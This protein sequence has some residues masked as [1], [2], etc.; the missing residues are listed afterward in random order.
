MMANIYNNNILA[1]AAF[2][3]N[4]S[5]LLAATIEAIFLVCGTPNI[6]VSK[7]PLPLKRWHELIVGPRQIVLG[8]VINTIEMTV[9]ITNNY[10]TKV[11][12][13]LALWDPN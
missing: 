10:I 13:L 11:R 8:L 4:M 3:G 5:K 9:G 1:A 6:V 12:N 2:R 7:C